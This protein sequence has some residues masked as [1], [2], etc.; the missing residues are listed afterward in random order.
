MIK[1]LITGGRAPSTLEL[2][3]LLCKSGHKIF[4]AES[5]YAHI[6]KASKY[7]TSIKISPPATKYSDFINDLKNIITT[8]K[9][10]LLIPTCEEIFYIS[11]GKKILSQYCKVFCDNFTILNTLH[12]KLKFN[13]KLKNLGFCYPQSIIANN[14][15]DVVNLLKKHKK[16]IIK[17]IYSRFAINTQIISN[18]KQLNKVNYNDTLMAQQFI[19]G[20]EIC[21][22]S[23][24]IDGKIKANLL[25][26]PYFKVS[27]GAGISLKSLLHE[28]INAWIA[29]FIQENNFSGQ[30]GFDF[31]Q[32]TNGHIYA[33]ECNPR[34]TSG[35]HFF[36]NYPQIASAYLDKSFTPISVPANIHKAL[37]LA[38]ITLGISSI[39][40]LDQAK[41]WLLTLLKAGDMVFKKDDI[42][43]F[44]YQIYCLVNAFS[45]SRKKRIPLL[46][47]T[48][49]DIEYNGEL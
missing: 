4:I 16:I 8:Y 38:L 1:I 46:R 33:I 6:C 24:A 5:N 9:I 17:P 42:K 14:K 29:I 43:P 19:T 27:S 31:I 26:E 28:K 36:A 34:L 48:T 3:R 40:N 11:K 32:C 2:S 35:I 45:Q 37:F 20:K 49:A 21:S 25:Y 30:I 41:K 44:F 18:E 23:I 15:S 7:A 39:N 47:T 10:D 13:Q 22:F 12:N